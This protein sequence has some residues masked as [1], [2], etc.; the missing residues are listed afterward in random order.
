MYKHS[1][2]TDEY[3]EF[4]YNKYNVLGNLRLVAN[5]TDFEN[6]ERKLSLLKK[7]S[8]ESNDRI[9]IEHFDTDYYLDEF[10]YGLTMYNLFTVFRKL[11][12]PLFTMLMVT[13]SF[14]IKHEVYRLVSNANDCPTVIETFIS[15][16]HY[17][18]DYQD[19]PIDADEITIPGISMIGHTRTHRNALYHYIEDNNLLDVIAVAYRKNIT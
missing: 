18:T 10:P 8:Y 19:M 17:T 4:I 15:W 7:D 3:H 13:N 6:V 1:E 5:D 2:L 12:I 11:D 16:Y 9:V 14:G